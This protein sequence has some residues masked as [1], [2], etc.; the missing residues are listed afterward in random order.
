MDCTLLTR[1]FPPST[2]SSS[3][4][5]SAWYLPLGF[6]FRAK[7]GLRQI[8]FLPDATSDGLRSAPLCLFP[9]FLQNTLSVSQVQ[10]HPQG[11]PWGTSNGSRVSC[12]W[13]WAGCSCRFT[14]VRT[15]LPCLNSWSGVSTARAPRIWPVFRSSLTCSPRS[16]STCMLRPSFSNAW[17]ADFRRYGPLYQPIFFI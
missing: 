11:W 14:C 10:A 1:L 5:I 2:S 13:F 16:Q 8:I 7:G 12:C 4:C 15:S 9:I 6:T 3:L 17:W